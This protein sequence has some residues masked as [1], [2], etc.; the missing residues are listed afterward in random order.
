[1]ELPESAK[2]KSTRSVS[3][4]SPIQKPFSSNSMNKPVKPTPLL[5]QPKVIGAALLQRPI[6]FTRN[7]PPATAKP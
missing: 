2:H 5:F 1:M 6:G 4:G 3:P 7:S